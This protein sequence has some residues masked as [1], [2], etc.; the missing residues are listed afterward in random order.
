MHLTI[1]G[2]FLIA[3]LLAMVGLF[4]IGDGT[5]MLLLAGLLF[6]FLGVLKARDAALG[7]DRFRI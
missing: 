7:R 4:W 3:W 1:A 2:V 5:H 6:L